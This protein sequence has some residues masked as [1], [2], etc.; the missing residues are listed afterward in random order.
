MHLIVVR[1]DLIGF[2][3]LHPV[4]GARRH[5]VDAAD[6]RRRRG[7]TASSP[8]SPSVS[9]PTRWV[10]PRRWPASSHHRPVPAAVDIVTDDRGLRV[11]RRHDRGTSG[12][13]PS[14]RDGRPVSD[15]LEDYLGAKGHLVALRAADLAFLH[16]HPDAI[17]CAFAWPSSRRRAR[18]ARGAVQDRRRP[19]AHRRLHPGRDPMSAITLELPIAGMTCASCATRV[20]RKLNKL[21]GVTASVN[22]A[23]EKATVE[24]D[25]AT[26]RPR[27]S[28]RGGRGRR[29]RRG[30]LPDRAEPR[31]PAADR[32]RR[33]RSLVARA[34]VGA[35]R[36]CWR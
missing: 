34:A 5:V 23:T 8:T 16:V 29:L 33:R 22:Y 24:F 17:G 7:R 19:A 18:T 10:R 15:R 27:A 20:E 25:P 4:H 35:G 2:Q 6:A 36:C 28:R 13:R 31:R 11:S 30:R 3:H 26:V 14:L 32:V 1:R 21:D 12:L 9:E